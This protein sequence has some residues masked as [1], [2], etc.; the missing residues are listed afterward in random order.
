MLYKKT[1]FQK[2]EKSAIRPNKLLGQHFLH[3]KN[4]LN[5]IIETADLNKNDVVLEVGPGLGV[6]TKELAKYAG[7]VVAVEK[8]KTLAEIL[9]RQLAEEQVDNVKIVPDDILKINFS[10]LFDS[11]D[12]KV[13]ANIPYYLTSH[14]IRLLLENATP[15]GEIVLLIQK[16]VA[17]RIC[18]KPPEM[19]LLA[20]SVQFY[21]EAKI[22]ASVSRKSF[23][24]QPKVD[25]AVIKITLHTAP[26]MAG[27]SKTFFQVVH[28]GFSHPRKQLLGN[29]SQELKIEKAKLEL[30]LA[31]AGIKNSQRAET[32]KISDW[33]KLA[34]LILNP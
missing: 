33:I 6:L 15:P 17:K 3:D 9:T 14:L 12:Y 20:V 34:P 7:Q 5:K 32:L 28:A 22:V 18:A 30:A 31:T 19:S 4:V 10:P 29:L 26:L 23:R 1:P 8:D 21:A 25:S 27:D 11:L 2:L 13:V 16:E 24:P